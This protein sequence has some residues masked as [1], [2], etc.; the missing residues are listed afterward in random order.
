VGRSASLT[1][2]YIN[3]QGDNM[4][5][6]AYTLIA[7]ANSRFVGNGHCSEIVQDDA[8]IDWI[9]F[10]GWDVNNSNNGRVLLLNKVNWDRSGWPYFTSSSPAITG[11]KPTFGPSGVNEVSDE[12]VELQTVGNLLSFKSL[13]TVKVKIYAVGGQIIK[14]FDRS[15]HFQIQLASGI[16]F[17]QISTKSNSIVKKIII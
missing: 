11:D 6:N 17:I 13:Q 9:F 10:H 3:K 8:G 5:S 14:S 16:Y 15:D 1:G 12:S 7:G 4:M 2:P